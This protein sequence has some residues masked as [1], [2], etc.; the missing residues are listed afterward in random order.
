M[1]KMPD[2]RRHRVLI[3][4]FP[5]LLPPLQLF[6]FG[7][8]TLYAGNQQEF[9][10]PF[11]NMAVHLVPMIAAI[12]A[13]LVVIGLALPER[14][15]RHYLVG[16]VG[17][18]IV[19]WIQGNLVVGD[20]GLLNGDEIDWSSHAWRNRYEPILWL[21]VPV[22][23]IVFTRRVF[24]T[25][26]F[27]SRILVALQIALLAVTAAKADPEARAKWEGAP[28]AIFELSSKQNVFHFVLDGFQSDVFLDIVES[29]RAE[30]DRRFPGFTFFAN[31][32]GAFPTTIVSIPAMLTGQVY[33]NQEPMRRFM[34]QQFKRASI[35]GVMRSQGYQVDVVSGLQYDKAS[36]TNYYRLP[37]PYVTYEAY[38]KFTAWQLADL[39]LFRHS[40]HLLKPAI[41]N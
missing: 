16:L 32:A 11:W 7:P 25:A 30:M 15:Y 20:Y 37:T 34:A 9:S 29:D 17:V 35:Y 27:A 18:G 14:L 38:V 33:R 26:V 12:T 1:P 36:A 28:D 10:A 21:A 6:L 24:S 8:H 22:V 3:L 5:A 2:S 31:H 40:P 19:L 13:A 23:M 41:Y 4:L 39:S